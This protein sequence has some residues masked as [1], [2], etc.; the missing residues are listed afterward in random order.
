MGK[1]FDN[2]LGPSS[3][4]TVPSCDVLLDWFLWGEC[5]LT[6]LTGKLQ[7]SIATLCYK[8]ILLCFLNML[9]PTAFICVVAFPT[10]TMITTFICVLPNWFVSPI[11]VTSSTRTTSKSSRFDM[12]VLA[13][14]VS[15][16]PFVFTCPVSAMSLMSFHASS[17][18][19]DTFPEIFFTG[20]LRM[21]ELA[22]RTIFTKAPV[23]IPTFNFRLFTILLLISLII[24]VL[25]DIP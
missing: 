9:L 11:V 20:N 2:W 24:L 21:I 1:A 23:E 15:S 8:V 10:I 13:H 19:T 4:S 5:C 14:F 25:V 3:W 16:A 17:L 18:Q 12:Q 6:Y 22:L 7:L